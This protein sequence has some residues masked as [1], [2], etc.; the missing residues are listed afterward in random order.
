[1]AY[2]VELLPPVVEFLR[3][4]DPKMRAKAAREGTVWVLALGASRLRTTVL[5]GLDEDR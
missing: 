5:E 1:M 3:G 4:M 2:D